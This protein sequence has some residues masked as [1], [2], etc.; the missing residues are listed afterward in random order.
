MSILGAMRLLMADRAM[1][2]PLYLAMYLCLIGVLICWPGT[3]QV[4][5]VHD[6]SAVP[7]LSF[8]VERLEAKLHKAGEPTTEVIIRN[9]DDKGND[10]E[11]DAVLHNGE[12]MLR[13]GTTPS[14]SLLGDPLKLDVQKG[15]KWTDAEVFVRNDSDLSADDLGNVLEFS[16]KLRN[17]QGD[18]IEP[19]ISVYIEKKSK[20]RT[21]GAHAIRPVDLKIK[22]NKRIEKY[23]ESPL[24]GYLVV[25]SKATAEGPIA[26]G[27]LSLTLS[28]AKIRAFKWHAPDD[29]PFPLNH[30]SFT[31]FN[32]MILAPFLLSFLVMG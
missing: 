22:L 29:W 23:A 18:L 30:L 26:P 21:L 19:P 16:A 15:K 31:L 1:R 4:A 7:S 2:I 28:K 11:F 5:W 6:H 3:S 32:A 14:L 17:S 13:S 8:R 9:G 12:D 10:L 20:V 27:T 24:T 25:S